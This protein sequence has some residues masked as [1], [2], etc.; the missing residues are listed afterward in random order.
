MTDKLYRAG[1]ELQRWEQAFTVLFKTN[2]QHVMDLERL[3]ELT[4]LTPA[5]LDLNQ[6]VIDMLGAKIIKQADEIERLRA[7][8]KRAQ[9]PAYPEMLMEE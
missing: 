4:N 8:I 3:L 1:I 7:V 5:I 9:T 6:R 2:E